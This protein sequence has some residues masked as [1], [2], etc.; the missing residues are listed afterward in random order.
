MRYRAC[1]SRAVR[2][3]PRM[4]SHH[5]VLQHQ[6]HR[7]AL[8]WIFLRLFAGRRVLPVQ[9]SPSSEGLCGYTVLTWHGG[10]KGYIASSGADSTADEGPA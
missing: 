10:S 2:H 8:P 5:R 6:I 9:L 7:V 3:T 4:L 1:F